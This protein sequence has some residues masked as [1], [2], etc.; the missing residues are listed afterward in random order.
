MNK[1]VYTTIDIEQNF[2]ST[3]WQN[4]KK[5]RDMND[6]KW[7]DRQKPDDNIRKVKPKQLENLVGATGNATARPQPHNHLELGPSVNALNQFTNAILS[8]NFVEFATEC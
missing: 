4:F 2:H 8:L 7:K 3:S 5:K 1:D 6:R